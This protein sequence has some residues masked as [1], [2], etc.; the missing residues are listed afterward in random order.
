MLRIRC[1]SSL[2]LGTEHKAG[3]CWSLP[4]ISSSAPL[5][6]QSKCSGL[7]PLPRVKGRR[8]SFW[9]SKAIEEKEEAKKQFILFLNTSAEL[10]K[11][12]IYA[13]IYV[14]V[15][16]RVCKQVFPV[17]PDMRFTPP[18]RYFIASEIP[19]F[20][21]HVLCLCFMFMDHDAERTG[22][23]PLYLHRFPRGDSSLVD[24]YTCKSRPGSDKFLHRKC[25]DSLHIH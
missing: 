12:V 16:A 6:K 9:S 20:I 21:F 4:N 10:V 14:C 24:R 13:C 19:V 17:L 23:G 18:C 7:G 15:C 5:Y 22:C 11:A 3:M 1:R 25:L 8:G 2:L